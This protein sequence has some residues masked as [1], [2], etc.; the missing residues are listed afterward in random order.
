MASGQA[1]GL[2]SRR[3]V[4]PIPSI[5]IDSGISGAIPHAIRSAQALLVNRRRNRI[6]PAIGRSTSRLQWMSNP[7]GGFSRY[8][9]RS[10][11]P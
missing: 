6:S 1:N 5:A 10:Y 2:T 7:A 3:T 11:Q 8:C 4:A 9:L